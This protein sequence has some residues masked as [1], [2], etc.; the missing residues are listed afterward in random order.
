MS[1]VDI[2]ADR[3][4]EPKTL[5][6]S[7]STDGLYIAAV[8]LYISLVMLSDK[9]D[10]HMMVS[11]TLLSAA[12]YLCLFAI[13]AKTIIA[14]DYL[15]YSRQG[16]IRLAAISILAV[17]VSL[18][19][20]DRTPIHLLIIIVGAY[21][22]R[23]EKIAKYILIIQG[24]IFGIIIVLSML[25]IT[26]SE[27]TYRTNTNSI[28]FSLGFSY[29][30]YPAILMYYFTGLYIYLRNKQVKVLEIIA[31]LILNGAMYI[32]TATR[33]EALLVILMLLGAAAIKTFNGRLIERLLSLAPIIL[34]PLF[35]G[36]SLVSAYI[37][38]SGNPAMKSMNSLLSDRLN[39]AHEA[40]IEYGIP[41]FGQ[42]I[43]WHNLEDQ[44]VSEGEAEFNFVDNGYLN[45]LLNYGIVPTAIVLLGFIILSFNTRNPYLNLVLCVMYVHT[46][47]TPQML[48][49]VY[50]AYLICLCPVL[51]KVDDASLT[52]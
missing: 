8:T 22:I 19:S 46:L 48:Q 27:I 49:I 50:D 47:F 23:F 39:L 3:G 35:L 42:S 6:P 9:T 24:G 40:V 5:R 32:L 1:T 4:T 41:L 28:R 18:I 29:T 14:K 21:G 12:R 36:V 16:I 31:L 15:G 45:M 34:L 26:P 13:I 17:L 30:T 2:T 52:I 33:T 44:D 37:Y 20:N 11:G 10:I 51:L 43:E 38:D 7:F 25:G